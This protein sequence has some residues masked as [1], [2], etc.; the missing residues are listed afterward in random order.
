MNLGLLHT[1]IRGDEKLLISAARQLKNLNLDVVDVRLLHLTPNSKPSWDLALERCLSTT[2]GT[3]TVNYLETLGLPVINNS[4]V[5]S[6]CQNKLLTSSL[7]EQSG[8]AT[9]RFAL[10]FD[11]EQ[12]L[13]SVEELGGYPIVLKPVEGS[14]GRLIAKVSDQDALEALIEHKHFLGGP[15]QRPLYLQEFIAKPERDIR[16]TTINHQPICAIYRQ[17]DHWITNTAKGATAQS[18]PL[19][20]DLE[21]ICIKTSQAIGGGILGIDLFETD[22]GYL[23]NEVNHTIEFKNVQ[24][25]TGVNVARHIIN[26]CLKV[27][28]AQN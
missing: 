26:Y 2:I 5:A 19:T 21:K 27:H 8:I 1:T 22:H 3:L 4:T 28:R 20:P 24:A 13:N 11:L 18:C 23:V 6:R 14:W 12:A 17:A 15:L 25:V 9:P 7:L 10:V 16:V